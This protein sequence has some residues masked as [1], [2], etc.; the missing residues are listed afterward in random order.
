MRDPLFVGLDW[1]ELR[2]GKLPGDMSYPPLVRQPSDRYSKT[3]HNIGAS[4]EDMPPQPT[5]AGLCQG[6][7]HFTGF[8]DWVSP[9]ILE[10]EKLPGFEHGETVLVSKDEPCG[11]KRP[12]CQGPC[13]YF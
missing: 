6:P 4:G 10:D 2:A 11:C 12:N 3:W 7:G 8:D 9:A 5:Y 13:L 1:D